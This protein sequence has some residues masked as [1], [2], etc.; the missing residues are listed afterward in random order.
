MKR[1]INYTWIVLTILF[2][3]ISSAVGAT[4]A[5]A[6]SI[7]VVTTNAEADVLTSDGQCSLRE[8]ITNANYDN[9]VYANCPAGSGADVIT[10][11]ANYTIT[12]SYD[13]I[14]VTSPI[15]IT[16][17]GV[18]NTI[19]QANASPNTATWR[20]FEVSSTGNLTLSG[21]T[22]RHGR[23][24][25]SCQTITGAGGGIYNAGTLTV[26]NSTLSANSASYG[27]GIYNA[28][29]LTVTNSTLSANIASYGGGIY[30]D[31]SLTIANSTLSSNS[32]GG[33]GGGIFNTS[34]GALT[35]ANSTLSSN[36]ASSAG[37]GIYNA[38]TLTV[39]DSTL[40]AN[41]AN[42]GG[43]IFN[44]I[45]TLIL[46]NSTL[47]ANSANYGGGINNEGTLTVANSTF[48]GN[49]G[50]NDG[51]GIFNAIYADGSGGITTLTNST[52]AGN[53]A[54]TSGGGGI[55]NSFG[56][57]NYANTIIA[58]STSGG[59]CS[60]NGGTISTNTNN[61][62]RDGSCSASLSGDPNLGPLADNGGPTQTFALLP[63]SPAIDA[64]DDATCAAS[65]VN[66]LDQ[67]GV[68]RP[69]G[70]HCDIGAYEFDPP[71]IVLS[72]TRANPN[73]THLASVDFTVTFSEGVTGVDTGDF[74]LT[75]SG[76][77]G[78]TVSGVSGSGSVYT[79]TV[80]TGSGNGTICLDLIDDDSI[81][82]AALN[83]LGG[84]GAGN[85]NFTSGETYTVVRNSLTLRSIGTEDGHVLESTET[86]KVGGTPNSTSTVFQLGDDAQ[87]RQYRGILHFDT[88]SLPDNAVVT[89]VT[90]KIRKQGQVGA[91]P[92]ATLGKIMV[93]IRTGAFS[94]N[95]ALQATDFHAA[96]HKNAGAVIQN[97]PINNWYSV[98][99]P[100]ASI[101]FLNL[102][103]VTQFRLRF[104]LDDNDNATA[105]FLKFY[106]GNFTTAAARPTLII[107]YYIP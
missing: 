95:N 74:T 22:V 79:V 77:S 105:D 47:S 104:Q 53:S 72:I 65:P 33:S 55:Y 100:S 14:A 44:T 45:G 99:F 52:F 40:S 13:Q 81:L 73:P 7:I 39:T 67:R 58:N 92:F 17:N 38:R 86:S 9:A 78:A 5:H 57:L 97:T 88:S 69:Q 16:G 103:G 61:L 27:G 96:A 30:N 60:N 24:N 42:K 43:G 93:D 8:A 85:G 84:A 107:E 20:V 75:T 4:P 87:D 70:S 3:L 83:P 90:L 46:T 91:N 66:N 35:I 51:G 54:G 80:S 36:A 56:T 15:T 25:G 48:S 26:T 89:K 31:G 71:P 32:A 102:T 76:V 29:T 10:F 1:P 2:A 18:G 82:D 98:V 68:A 19:I 62:V 34:G 37:G 41:S 64:G 106:S 63:G 12:L 94:N 21:L 23:C 28:R 50:G 59:D 6:E 101:P 49:D 11:A